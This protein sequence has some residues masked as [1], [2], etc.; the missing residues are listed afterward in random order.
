MIAQAPASTNY[1]S[2]VMTLA[3]NPPPAGLPISKIVKKPTL[4]ELFSKKPEGYDPSGDI[5]PREAREKNY[6]IPP[7]IL[8]PKLSRRNKEASEVLTNFSLL[9][10]RGHPSPSASLTM[11]ITPSRHSPAHVLPSPAYKHLSLIHQTQ[12]ASRSGA[13]SSLTSLPVSSSDSPPSKEFGVGSY[14]LIT[15]LGPLS[16]TVSKHRT[17]RVFPVSVGVERSCGCPECASLKESKGTRLAD[18]SYAVPKLCGAVRFV[19]VTVLGLS[20]GGLGGRLLHKERWSD[21]EIKGVVEHSENFE[22]AKRNLLLPAESGRVVE[23]RWGGEEPVDPLKNPVFMTDG[24]TGATVVKCGHKIMSYSNYVKE[25]TDKQYDKLYGYEDVPLSPRSRVKERVWTVKD[26]RL[27]E[28]AMSGAST[29]AIPGC[30]ESSSTIADFED[31]RSAG[32]TVK[33]DNSA[34]LRRRQ[35]TGGR[36]LRMKDLSGWGFFN[37]KPAEPEPT[38][39]SEPPA[40]LVIDDATQQDDFDN[41]DTFSVLSDVAAS[42]VLSADEAVAHVV[43]DVV[44]FPFYLPGGR[45]VISQGIVLPPGMML[46]HPSLLHSSNFRPLIKEFLY[47]WDGTADEA[48]RAFLSNG[49]RKMWLFNCYFKLWASAVHAKEEARCVALTSARIRITVCTGGG[50]VDVLA[51]PL[52]TG[53]AIADMVWGKK[54]R[55]KGMILTFEETVIDDKRTLFDAGVEDRS[56]L[57]M[58]F[59]ATLNT[60]N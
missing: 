51:S 25:I 60:K 53:K 35:L 44:T 59:P 55:K 30:K 5:N 28:A 4:G 21:A 47:M 13:A 12:F 27:K 22:R 52:C 24:K 56:T 54:K 39:P 38:P 7:P 50:K 36:V 20:A 14:R 37:S 3:P 48:S 49:V 40:L 2:G 18:A 34:E 6:D 23:E 45:K 41:Y 10:S 58:R 11:Q 8:P 42:E 33:S 29:K 31:D 1:K 57:W 15:R 17:G 19:L 16:F 26:V 9:L 46:R 32:G 43:R